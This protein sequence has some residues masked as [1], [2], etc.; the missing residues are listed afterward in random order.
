MRRRVGEAV[1]DGLI[2]RVSSYLLMRRR[3]EEDKKIEREELIRSPFYFL[4]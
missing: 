2:I 4:L 3:A 1:T